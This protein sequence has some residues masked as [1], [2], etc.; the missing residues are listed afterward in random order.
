MREPEPVEL[1]LD[2]E[3]GL[4]VRWSDGR[5]SFYPVALLRRLSP[6]AEQRELR[7]QM[8]RNP[9]TVLPT[10]GGG[11]AGPLRAL[12]AQLVGNYALR[13]DF[14][15]GHRTGLFTWRYLREID[16][17]RGQGAAEE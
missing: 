11:E 14:S 5:E 1:D 8:E 4:S 7:K 12:D 17:A 2:R 9:L 13:I 15:D 3:R 16:P 6:S 10:K